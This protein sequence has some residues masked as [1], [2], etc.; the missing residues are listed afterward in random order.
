MSLKTST[1][2]HTVTVDYEYRGYYLKGAYVLCS[3]ERCLLTGFFQKYTVT[4][5]NLYRTNNS[6]KHPVFGE[7]NFQKTN[8]WE[9]SH[10]AKH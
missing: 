7:I 9:I 1:V 10:R 3:D 8:R 5:A 2:I 6:F 4:F